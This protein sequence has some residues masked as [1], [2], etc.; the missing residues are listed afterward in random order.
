M[1]RH[2]SRVRAQVP[3]RSRMRTNTG[4]GGNRH[5]TTRTHYN[6]GVRG[7]FHHNNRTRNPGLRGNSHHTTRTHIN[8]GVRGNHHNQRTNPN[9][10]VRGNHHNQRTN[11]NPVNAGRGG[12]HPHRRGNSNPGFRGK[13]HH[14][15]RTHPNS[16]VRGN[17]PHNQ[18]TNPNPG[19]RQVLDKRRVN[20]QGVKNPMIRGGKTVSV[21]ELL[22]QKLKADTVLTVR[23]RVQRSGRV[24]GNTRNTLS[25]LNLLKQKLKSNRVLMV[26]PRVQ[27]IPPAVT[28]HP[29]PVAAPTN[30]RTV[31]YQPRYGV[32]HDH[33]DRTPQPAIHNSGQQVACNSATA[34]RIQ[35]L[36]NTPA[37]N[38]NISEVKDEYMLF[39]KDQRADLIDKVK[40]VVRIVDYLELSNEKAAIVRAQLTDQAMMRKL[41]EFT[42]SRRAAEL[43]IN[44]LWEQA[45][46][47]ME[48]LIDVEDG[49]DAGD[50]AD[51]RDDATDDATDDSGDDADARD[52]AGV[53]YIVNG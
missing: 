44:V 11:P 46:D 26:R 24:R 14:T 1:P 38:E 6:P 27:H 13:T 30:A 8:P 48:D 50:D 3:A 37:D 21:L 4:F 29:V 15:K 53:I 9:P 25:V 12:L 7:N 36:D 39:L 18:R 32:H 42:T 17:V 43:L 28:L 31:S 22:K 35:K 34:A 10:G 5:H 20:V 41:L 49:D 45:G 52:D 47:V 16:G 33:R 2:V 23:P 40:N 19:H 51:A